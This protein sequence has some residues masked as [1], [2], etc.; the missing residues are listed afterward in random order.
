MEAVKDNVGGSPEEQ[1]AFFDRVIAVH[2][3][4][5][6]L[7]GCAAPCVRGTVISFKLKP[8]AKPVAREP[9]PM[10]PCNTM[11][12]EYHLEEWSVQGKIRKNDTHAWIRTR[13]VC[14]A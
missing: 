10:S 5:F 13:K 1:Q 8:G 4:Q 9:I 3:Q 12:A 11:R 2:P 14:W 7:E 6:W